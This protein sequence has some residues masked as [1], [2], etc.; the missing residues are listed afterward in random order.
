MDNNDKFRY[1]VVW[2]IS[3][4]WFDGFI[5]LLIFANCVLMGM[6]DYLDRE[7]KTPINNLI[8]R[9]DPYFNTV[10]V[11]ECVLKIIGLGFINGKGAYLRDGWNW[12]DFFVVSSTVIQETVKLAFPGGK[13]SGFTAFRAV[14]LLRP[15]RLLGRI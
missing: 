5:L 11:L 3:Q 13:E 1:T 15:L 8:E 4:K 7:N 12:L 2:L 9:L 6:K 14:R 10:I